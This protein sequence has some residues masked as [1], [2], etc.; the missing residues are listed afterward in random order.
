[1]TAPTDQQ[2]LDSFPNDPVD[3]DNKE[4]YRARLQR[5]LVINRCADCGRWSQPPRGICP[6]CWSDA[7]VA[8][9]VSGRGTVYLT[10]MLHQGPQVPGVDYST[11]H[12]VVVV[13]LEE[14]PGLR[15]TATMTGVANEDIRI[16]MPVELTWLDRG[17]EPTPA[18]RPVP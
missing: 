2:V 3:H 15:V 6:A 5:R 11:P 4:Y 18:F 12:P 7:V 1:V 10:L 9:E 16:G 13:E 17:G 8:T 14:Q